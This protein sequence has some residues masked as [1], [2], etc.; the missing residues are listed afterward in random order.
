VSLKTLASSL[1]LAASAISTTSTAPFPQKKILIL[2]VL[3]SMAPKCGMKN[4]R[5][6]ITIELHKRG[7]AQNTEIHF[8]VQ[9]TK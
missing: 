4:H 2:M 7:G 9:E 1:T 8:V 3:S 6:V 5:S